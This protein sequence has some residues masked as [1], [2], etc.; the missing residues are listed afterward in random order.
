MSIKRIF[1]LTAVG[2]AFLL[3]GNAFEIS[4]QTCRVSCGVNAAGHRTYKEV[5]EYDYVAEK[6][7]FPGGDSK[8]LAFVN[9]TREYP[10]EAYKAGIEG[11]V[12]CSFV[13]NADG[14]ISHIKVLKG[15]ERSL[16]YEAIRILSQMPAWKPG[17]HDSHPVPVR[18]IYPIAFRK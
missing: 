17:R 9:E 16:N 3:S 12:L 2:L 4:A 18:V 8:L 10:A 15:V 14:S 13:V 7:T 1:A 11:R 5:Y 6:P